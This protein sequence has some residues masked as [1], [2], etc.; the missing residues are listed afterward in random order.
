MALALSVLTMTARSQQQ[1]IPLERHFYHEIQRSIFRDSTST[2]HMG[3]RPGLLRR[4]KT[5]RT[6][7]YQQDSAKYYYWVTSRLFRDHLVEIQEGDFRCTIDPL[8]D[9]NMGWDLLDTS[10]YSDTTLLYTNS[11]GMLIQ[12]DIGKSL[13]FQSGFI[14]TQAFLPAFQREWIAGEGIVP[15]MGR[16]KV[17]KGP[18]CSVELMCPL[19]FILFYMY[20]KV[21][22]A[23]PVF[24]RVG[25]GVLGEGPEKASII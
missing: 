5:E 9:L 2:I 16:A 13:S 6:F 18:G 22:H 21:F 12:A 19:F 24:Q 14:E 3:M 1:S 7:G 8:F 10:G 25:S 11:R 4:V 23:F 20:L 15:G 17:F